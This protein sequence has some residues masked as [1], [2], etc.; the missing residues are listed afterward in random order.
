MK[1]SKIIWYFAVLLLLTNCKKE[2]T[3][4]INVEAEI[5]KEMKA[6]GIPSLAA[7]VVKDNQISW[8]GIYGYANIDNS[9]EADRQT[10]Y[11]IMSISKLFMV[12]AVMQLDEQSK[13]DLDTDIN[14]YLPKL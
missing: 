3:A 1:R 9:R 8:E 12:V 14:K 11:T 10:I 5:V 4:N 2:E 7:C 6:E 13:I